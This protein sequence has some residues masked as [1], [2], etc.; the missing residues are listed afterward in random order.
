MVVSD[1]NPWELISLDDY[2]KHMS[3]ESVHCQME[4]KALSETMTRLGYGRIFKD[5]VPLPNG[6][7]LLRLDYGREE[8]A[9]KRYW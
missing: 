6:K 1:H 2:E 7:A 3:L 4:E 9:D 8:I 5:S